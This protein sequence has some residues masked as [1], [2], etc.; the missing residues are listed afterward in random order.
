MDDVLPL[1]LR[2]QRCMTRAELDA[3]NSDTHPVDYWDKC[4]EHFNDSTM[5]TDN[6]FIAINNVFVAMDT[7]VG[8]ES[9]VTIEPFF[10]FFAVKEI[11][12]ELVVELAAEGNQNLFGIRDRDLAFDG[13]QNLLG[14]DQFGLPFSRSR[15]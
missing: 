14:I 8:T 10:T 4:C 13:I 11:F 3:C 6:V 1:Y 15:R 7:F 2:T 5:A 12:I 9:F